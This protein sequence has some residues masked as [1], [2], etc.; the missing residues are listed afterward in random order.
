MSDI[1]NSGSKTDH[2]KESQENKVNKLAAVSTSATAG[3]E[4]GTWEHQKKRL[5]KKKQLLINLSLVLQSAI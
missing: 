3:A 2:K 5:R 1:P 4:E